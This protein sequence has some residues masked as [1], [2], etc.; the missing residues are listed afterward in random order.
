M[1]VSEIHPDE[2]HNDYL[3]CSVAMVLALEHSSAMSKGIE[4]HVIAFG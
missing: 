3:F 2:W 4:F 1:L